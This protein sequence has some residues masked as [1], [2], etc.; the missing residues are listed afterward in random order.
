MKEMIC[1]KGEP[2]KYKN[3]DPEEGVVDEYGYDGYECEVLDKLDVDRK[4]KAKKKD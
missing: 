3:D 1:G 2:T 4:A